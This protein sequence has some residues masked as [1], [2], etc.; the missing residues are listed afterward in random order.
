MLFSIFHVAW[1]FLLLV[2]GTVEVL[3][4]F[5]YR[6]ITL[7][8]GSLN[9]LENLRQLAVSGVW[10]IGATLVMLLGRLLDIRALRAAAIVYFGC[11][12][13]KAFVFD[14]MMLDTLYRIAGFLALSAILTA[15]S[16]LYYRNRPAS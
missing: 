7:G 5:E 14:L 9:Q 11:T 3:S 15:V 13:V 1:S 2:W 8:D 10:L 4:Y 6:M 12:V 16:Y